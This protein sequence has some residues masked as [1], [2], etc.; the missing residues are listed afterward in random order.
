ME[1]YRSRGWVD[2]HLPSSNQQRTTY[3]CQYDWFGCLFGCACI[4]L[5]SIRFIFGVC[6]FA[7][8]SLSMFL[9][10]VC[11][12]LTVDRDRQSQWNVNATKYM[13]SSQLPA[14]NQTASNPKQ[15]QFRFVVFHISHTL[16]SH[17]RPLCVVFTLTTLSI[18]LTFLLV[19]VSF[20][21]CAFFIFVS[22]LLSSVGWLWHY[23]WIKYTKWNFQKGESE[24][25]VR[26][27]SIDWQW[28]CI[29]PCMLVQLSMNVFF[30][31][32]F[33]FSVSTAIEML[34]WQLC[35]IYVAYICYLLSL[36][37]SLCACMCMYVQPM[38]RLYSQTETTLQIE[39]VY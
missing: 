29:M 36:S 33:N 23:H 31:W 38:D 28:Q 1:R 16:N 8:L 25:C 13:A 3:R 4:P 10:I 17:S 37:V 35:N 30:L 18:R 5:L 11:C 12:A 39:S 7:F 14:H 32:N 20:C 15:K 34:N 24:P 2:R 9:L 22:P 27:K 21:L 19:F 6:V 26:H